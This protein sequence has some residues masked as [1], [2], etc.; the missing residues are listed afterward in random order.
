MLNEEN[1]NDMGDNIDI[2]MDNAGK[3]S[4]VPALEGIESMDIEDPEKNDEKDQETPTKT[5][6]K[7]AMIKKMAGVT[8]RY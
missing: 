4:Q 5:G 1:E 3:T 7:A 6:A 8:T 2:N